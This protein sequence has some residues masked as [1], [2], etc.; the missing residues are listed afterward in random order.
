M[1]SKN[2]HAYCNESPSLIENYNKAINDEKQIWEI[3]HRL[4]IEL[5]LTAKELIK[6]NLYFNRPASELIFLTRSE[7]RRLH[8]PNGVCDCKGTKNTELHNKNIS[9]GKIK[10]YSDPINRKK[11]SDALKGKH[12]NRRHMTNGINKVFIKPD[13]ID[14]YLERGYH[15]GRK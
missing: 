7:H 5:N 9:K 14:Y 13:E 2:F 8:T 12:K 1:I 15:F 6:R 4:E 11:Q 3:H 10:L